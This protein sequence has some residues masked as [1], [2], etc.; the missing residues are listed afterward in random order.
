MAVGETISNTGKHPVLMQV[1]G[2]SCRYLRWRATTVQPIAGEKRWVAEGVLRNAWMFHL[3][4]C[5]G[6][7]DRHGADS[8][9][10]TQ[11]HSFIIWKKTETVHLAHT[12]ASV[13]AQGERVDSSP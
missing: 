6:L 11:S 4:T 5:G 1:Q 3:Q 12:A 8:R 7:R 2:H 10:R 13:A 9:C